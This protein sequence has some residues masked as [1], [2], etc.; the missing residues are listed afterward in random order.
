VWTLKPWE[1]ATWIAIVILL[2]MM[3]AQAML[4]G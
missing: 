2:M 4:A 3:A 1:A